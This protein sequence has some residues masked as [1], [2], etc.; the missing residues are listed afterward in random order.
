MSGIEPSPPTHLPLPHSHIV[1]TVP[2]LLVSELGT[3]KWALKEEVV[4]TSNELG[5]QGDYLP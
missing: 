1:D 4:L 3:R 5:T 2:T